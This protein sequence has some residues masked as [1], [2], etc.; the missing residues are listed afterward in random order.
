MIRNVD[1]FER[2]KRLGMGKPDVATN[3]INA[4][5]FSAAKLKSKQDVRSER[6]E[7]DITTGQYIAGASKAYYN[8][9]QEG[10]AKKWYPEVSRQEG[11]ERPESQPAFGAAQSSYLK[12][13]KFRG[14]RD[15]VLFL[16]GSQNVSKRLVIAMYLVPATMALV[17]G[18][19]HYMA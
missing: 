12:S 5:Q 10:M 8:D 6:I 17:I 11:M 3:P 15:K 16:K 2:K 9:H 14:V 18:A 7:K 4:E 1:P 13:L 19:Q